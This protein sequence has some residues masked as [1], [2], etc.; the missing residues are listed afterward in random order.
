L[1][2][3][4]CSDDRAAES[5]GRVPLGRAETEPVAGAVVR[6]TG[7]EVLV[8]ACPKCQIHLKCA[9]ADKEVGAEIGIAV[10]DLGTMVAA[11][12]NEQ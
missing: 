11:Q 8:T 2:G 3:G 5:V 7:A 12:I 4:R 6:S 9:L 1:C 10:R